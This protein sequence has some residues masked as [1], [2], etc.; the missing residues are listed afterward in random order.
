M[1][2]NVV[3]E[4][5]IPEGTQLKGSRVK[6]THVDKLFGTTEWTLAN[7]VKIVVKPTTFKADEV[8]MSAVAKGGLSLLSN[9]DYYMG[10]IM[11]A[12]NLMS[13]VGKFSTTE[14]RKQLSGKAASVA[15]SV[16][17]YNSSMSGSASPKD[18]ENHAPACSISTSRS[19]VSTGPTTTNS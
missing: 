11:P 14:L 5:L 3:K 15:P 6:K 2:D 10:S 12:I 4:P 9:E 17:N 13:G 7:G 8:L 18:L 16:S 19:P 1:R